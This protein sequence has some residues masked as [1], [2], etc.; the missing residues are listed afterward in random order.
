MPMHHQ[1]TAEPIFGS[2]GNGTVLRNVIAATPRFPLIL[3]SLVLYAAL[4]LA[5]RLSPVRVPALPGLW[6]VTG[7]AWCSY[8][9]TRTLTAP[10]CGMSRRRA[11]I[12]PQSLPPSLL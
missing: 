1:D 6:A 9:A 10:A 8:G 11:G 3:E 4:P 5:Y 7:Y 2:A 12:C